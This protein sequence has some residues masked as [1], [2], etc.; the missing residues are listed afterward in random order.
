V[1]RT[2]ME[3]LGISVKVGKLLGIIQYFSEQKERG[4]GFSVGIAFLCT[5]ESS[6]NI[7]V[8]DQ[9]IE[10]RWFLDL[11]ENLVVEQKDFLKSI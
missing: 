5:P 2:A 4:F 10:A 6:I 8:N 7:N 3:E 11:P 1:K 9:A